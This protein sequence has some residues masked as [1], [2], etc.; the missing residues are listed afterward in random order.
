[1]KEIMRAAVLFS[2]NDLRAEDVEKPTIG[3]R[4]LLLKVKVCAICGT[5][6][7]IYSGKKTKGIRYPSVIGHEF[8]GE[9]AEVGSEVA[10]WKPGERVAVAPVIACRSCFYCKYGM[11]NACLNRTAMGYEFDGGFA[12]YI[13]I[14]SV[15][16]EAGNLF[17][18]PDGIS[19]EEAAM[20]EPLGC[21]LNG[22]KN[23]AITLNDTIVIIGAG[24]IGLMHIQVA[25]LKGAKTVI[26]TEPVAHRRDLARNLGADF[27]VAPDPVLVQKIVREQTGG[28]GADAVIMAVGVPGEVN[29]SIRLLRKGGRLNLFAGFPDA[30]E[31]TIEANL[32][33]YNEIQ[34]TGATA[35]TRKQFEDA[36]NLVASARVNVR[37][38]ISHTFPLD[39]I[40]EALS[41]VTQ[42][43]GIKVIIR[44]Y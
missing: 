32:I 20:V 11:E 8:S 17:Y 15:L 41:I 1:M 25:K 7:R 43:Y 33:H 37:K 28:I 38:L 35:C 44:L 24:P 27:A 9:I 10:G 30:G 3:P 6:I 16:I 36:L 39:G 31:T 26:V 40:N 4:E 22:S 5:D 13:R 2:P 42:G 12:E 14:P 29:N 18:I 23:A 34:V 19:F 21:V